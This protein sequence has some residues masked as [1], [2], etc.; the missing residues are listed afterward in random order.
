MEN[1]IEVPGVGALFPWN[2]NQA[3]ESVL[4]ECKDFTKDTFII[5][6]EQ[7]K[8]FCDMIFIKEEMSFGIWNK[9]RISANIKDSSI[10]IIKIVNFYEKPKLI[11]KL[12]N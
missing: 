12:V 5:V 9:I 7:T 4:I 6:S 11:A 8:L 2:I 1:I 3:I 10:E